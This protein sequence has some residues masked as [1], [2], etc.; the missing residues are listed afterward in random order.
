M[1]LP[2]RRLYRQSLAE[3]C[4]AR[5]PASSYTSLIRPWRSER[6]FPASAEC[7]RNY[8]DR[9]EG[10][11]TAGQLTLEGGAIAAAVATRVGAQVEKETRVSNG[12]NMHD[13]Q[14]SYRSPDQGGI[15]HQ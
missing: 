12:V 8:P 5:K 14:E 2:A 4:A 11:R 1:T 3:I 7:Q 13:G 10:Q 15:R 6:Q 9:R